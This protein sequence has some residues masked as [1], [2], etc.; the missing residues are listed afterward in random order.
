MD[1][2]I[3]TYQ[4]LEICHGSALQASGGCLLS[5]VADIDSCLV[6]ACL[7]N[8]H[9]RNKTKITKTTKN[10]TNNKQK[11]TSWKCDA[12]VLGFYVLD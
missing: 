11:K 10:K 4:R 6:A 8:T 2:Y 3:R 9:A 5:G 7:K 12:D 1:T